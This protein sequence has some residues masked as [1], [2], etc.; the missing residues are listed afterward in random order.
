MS[1]KVLLADDHKIVR[2]GLQVLL[3]RNS[4]FRVVG[5]ASNGQIAWDLAK[6]LNPDVV[7][8]DIGM[9]VMNGLEA[10]QH[11]MADLP[12]MKVI[13]LSMHSDR[14]FIENMMEAG[15]KGY[16]LKD[17]AFDELVQAIRA[18][19]SGQ[20]YISPNLQE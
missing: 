12:N 5:T 8:I 10:T 17:C 18:V 11:I 7:V 4:D 20:N 9:P 1:I 19:A 14:R 15:A 16:L 3:D 2:D 13:A 6:E